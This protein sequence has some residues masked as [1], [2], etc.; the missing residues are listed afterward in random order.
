MEPSNHSSSRIQKNMKERDRRMYMKDQLSQLASLIPL[1]SA[2]FTVPEILDKATS[3][4]KQLQE[5]EERLKRRKEQLKGEEKTTCN[6][7]TDELRTKMTIRHY[8]STVEVNLICA[9]DKNFLLHEVISVLQEEAA[10]VVEASQ[11]TAGDKLIFIIK[12]KAT[13]PRIGIEVSRIE[14][15]LK[16]LIL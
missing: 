14:Q 4:I 16:E 5:N 13:S 11:H 6:T 12:S 7:S 2:R 10:E 1:Q 15:K 3:Y 9:L 8:D